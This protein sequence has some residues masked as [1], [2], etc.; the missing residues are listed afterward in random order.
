MTVQDVAGEDGHREGW[1]V[2]L[3]LV[4][5]CNIESKESKVYKKDLKDLKTGI[6]CLC[7]YAT[8]LVVPG[9][10]SWRLGAQTA[11]WK[12]MMPAKSKEAKTR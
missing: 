7:C 5:L 4:L 1:L 8:S 12:V 11:T 9:R 3:S 2:E 6:N 10:A